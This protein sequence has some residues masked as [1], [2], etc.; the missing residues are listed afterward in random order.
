VVTSSARSGSTARR[1]AG[2]RGRRTEEPDVAPLGGATTITESEVSGV[3]GV[4][5][6]RLPARAR[7]EE[8]HARLLDDEQARRPD[9]TRCAAD[10][11]DAV[12]D[13]DLDVGADGDLLGGR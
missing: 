8:V 4:N 11:G 10:L 9:G 1:L 3:R 5:D 2:V 12:L 7:L 13:E 6:A